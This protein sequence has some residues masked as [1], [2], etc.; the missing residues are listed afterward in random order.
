MF[1][2]LA[3]GT[4]GSMD[5][6]TF[7]MIRAIRYGALAVVMAVTVSSVAAGCS[8]HDSTGSSG[9][10]VTCTDACVHCLVTTICGDCSGFGVRFRDEF[11]NGLYP[12]VAQMDAC[13]NDWQACATSALNALPQ[14][15]IDPTFRSACLAKRTECQNQ[16][17]GFADDDCLLSAAFTVDVVTEAEQCISKACS[18]ISACFHAAFEE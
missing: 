15:D 16:G 14:R 7:L 8:S 3:S 2:S 1:E 13:S 4:L 6:S 5:A 9:P 10:A 17:L 11:E 18:E 12:C